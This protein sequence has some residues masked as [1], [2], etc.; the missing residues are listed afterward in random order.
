MLSTVVYG[1]FL[2]ALNQFGVLRMLENAGEPKPA[3]AF[4]LLRSRNAG[5]PAVEP[6]KQ[7]VVVSC[8]QTTQRSDAI[9]QL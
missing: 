6:R 2:I 7:L 3:G 1:R 4:A 8:I 5:V 9:G